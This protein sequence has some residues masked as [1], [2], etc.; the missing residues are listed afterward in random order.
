MTE[1]E[2][3]K[4]AETLESVA[5]CEGLE[6]LIRHTEENSHGDMRTAAM[7][8][9]FRSLLNKYRRRTRNVKI[10]SDAYGDVKVIDN[11]LKRFNNN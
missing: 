7:L 8:L 10:Q 2:T 1:D 6:L 5:L 4:L 11:E 3:R 9:F